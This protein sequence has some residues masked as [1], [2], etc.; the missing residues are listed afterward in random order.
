LKDTIKE[1]VKTREAVFELGEFL[2]SEP[3]LLSLETKIEEY[4]NKVLHKRQLKR[5][6]ASYQ[7]IK[8]NKNRAEDQYNFKKQQYADM[9]EDLGMCP[10]C[11][12]DDV[13][14]VQILE[15]L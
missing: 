5:A 1:V 7:E 10:L 15:N 8:E 2:K 6:L 12:S 4:K 3:L 13:D 11:F 14:V 9:V